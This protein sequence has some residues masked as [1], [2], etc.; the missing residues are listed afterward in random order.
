[1]KKTKIKSQ[2]LNARVKWDATEVTRLVILSTLSLS[3]R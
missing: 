1:M 2:Q 3:V